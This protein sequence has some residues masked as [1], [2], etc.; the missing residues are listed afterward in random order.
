MSYGAL[1]GYLMVDV[2]TVVT[3]A[4]WNDLTASPLAFKAAAYAAFKEASRGASPLLLEP[5]MRL[6][7]SAP[8]DF[9][10]E[11]IRDL[12]SR[13]GM[14]EGVL[15]K[16]DL[17][18]VQATVP[19]RELFGYSTAVRSVSQGRASFTMQFDSYLP[20]RNTPP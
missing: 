15:A 11:I 20:A 19:L 6:E 8:D 16:G 12:G 2:R 14:V 4:R 7:V 13:S 3:A 18:V 10:G 9:V 1:G 17:R 5:V